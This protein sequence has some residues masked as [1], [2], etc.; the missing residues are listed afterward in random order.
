[1]PTAT[2]VALRAVVGADTSG[3]IQIDVPK[4]RVARR[5]VYVDHRESAGV[6]PTFTASADT[7][8]AL[9]GWVRTEDGVPVA[10]AQVSIFGSEVLATTNADGAFQLMRIHGG[11]QT[12]VTRAIGFVPD[13]RPVDLTDRHIPVIVGLTSL[14]RFLDTVHVRANRVSITSAVGFDNRR[15]LGAG[16]FF[17][18]DDIARLHILQFTDVLRHVPTLEMRSDNEHNVKIRM[19]GDMDACTPV[20]FVDGKQFINWELADLD[21]IVQP[22]QVAGLEIYT[23]SLTPAEFRTKMGC[24]TIVVWTRAS[25]PPGRRE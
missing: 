9:S 12:L 21:G 14:R 15:K 1:V 5:N 17:T 22:E 2:T 25:E 4:T 19:R 10:G 20:I 23:A 13:E 3:P 11:T 7:T 24:G 18:A 6:T 8:A 16:R